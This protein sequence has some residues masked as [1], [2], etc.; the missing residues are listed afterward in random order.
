MHSTNALGMAAHCTLH[1]KKISPSLP[2]LQIYQFPECDSDEDEDFKRQDKE[3]KECI[4][5]AVIGSHNIIEVGG[6]KVRG[7]QYPWGIVE[8]NTV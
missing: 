3:L 1:C 7:R 4:P 8:G 6:K 5:F 2:I